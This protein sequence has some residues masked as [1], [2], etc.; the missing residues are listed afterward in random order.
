MAEPHLLIIRLSSLGDV[1][2]ALPA[3]AALRRAFP[4]SRIDWLVEERWLPLLAGNP[5]L[6]EVITADT[7]AWR[8]SLMRRATWQAMRRCRRQLLARRYQIAMDFQGLYKSGLMARLSG[9]KEVFGFDARFCREPGAAVFY[10]RVI[11]PDGT[12]VVDLNLSLA[13][14]V[15]LALSPQGVVGSLARR[16]VTEY[17]SASEVKAKFPDEVKFFLP[18][19]EEA[20]AYVKQQLAA[21]QVTKFLVV[22]PGGGWKSKCWLPERYGELC[23]RLIRSRGSPTQGWSAV[24]SYGPGEESLVD[25]VRQ[26]A[27][28]VTLAAFPADLRQLMALLRRA[29][30]FIG[31]DTG[32]LHLAVAVGT[33]VVGLYGPTDPAR[34]GPY[35]ALDVVVCN[36]EYG[37]VTH[38]REWE[39]SLS[40]LSITV[41][42]V[43]GAVEQRLGRLAER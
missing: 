38:R 36:R 15:H 21:A 32:P 19:S 1:V 43:I 14:Q 8:R 20:E 7:I 40:M 26:A 34:N 25:A 11:V 2:H 28:D 37:G 31:G 16:T 33:P 29:A 18:R 4:E 10:D 3:A 42:Q 24:V 22:N 5:D 9:A 13:R 41:E 17:V 35:S 6:D 30:I 12:H 27:G 39:Y 23:R